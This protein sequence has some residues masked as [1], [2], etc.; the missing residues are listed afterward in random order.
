MKEMNERI[1]NHENRLKK[2]EERMG[3]GRKSK[4]VPESKATEDV[5]ESFKSLDL[6]EYAYVYDLSGL[7]L[8]LAVILV[9]KDALNIDGLTAP[10]I[11]TICKGKIRIST[12]VDRTTISNALSGAGAMVDR[13]DNPRGRG[14]AYKIMRD[15]ERY[16]QEVIN[17]TSSSK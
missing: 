1:A 9:A 14:Y 16:L 11:S 17:Q 3:F 6:S 13:I 8:F 4:P 10:E 2:L 12:G 7:P 5:V 15:G